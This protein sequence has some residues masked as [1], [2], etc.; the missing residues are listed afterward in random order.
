LALSGSTIR[1]RDLV[2]LIAMVMLKTNAQ[3]KVAKMMEKPPRT[4]YVSEDVC[5]DMLL[6]SWAVLRGNEGENM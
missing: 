6:L 2:A 5:E 1:V 3:V 4:Q